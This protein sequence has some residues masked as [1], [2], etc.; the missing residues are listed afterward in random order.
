MKSLIKQGTIFRNIC[1]TFGDCLHIMSATFQDFL[2]PSPPPLP[3]NR[4][5][6]PEVPPLPD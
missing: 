3:L 5:C 2:L 4:P 6:Q 1:A